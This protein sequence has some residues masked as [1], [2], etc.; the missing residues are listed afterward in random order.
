M[1]IHPLSGEEFDLGKLADIDP[2]H[3]KALSGIHF[4]ELI[5][6]KDGVVDAKKTALNFWRFGPE[7]DQS[8][9]PLLW[10]LLPADTRVP[11]HTI[12]AHLDL[13]SAFAAAFV[14]DSPLSPAPF[15]AQGT[16]EA[17][18]LSMSFGP[19]QDFI[20][21]SRST[22]DL[23]AGSCNLLARIAWEGL[24]VIADEIGPDAVIFPQLRGVPQVDLWL[25]DE[26]GLAA[27]RFANAEW[28]TETTDANPLFMAALPNKFVAI[29]PAG[30]AADLAEKVIAA[31]RSWVTSNAQAMLAELLELLE[32]SGFAND[33]ALPCH[34]NNW[35]SSSTASPKC[36]GPPCLSR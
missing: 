16:G 21:Q 10:Q 26:I 11:D 32:K 24:K 8:T 19:V 5:V 23:W 28:V 6:S 17:A 15:P 31:V 33:P 34:H 27:G 1:L 7:P 14:A 13:T 36:I 29:V 3:I 20:A 4:D 9:L 35:P 22:S 25:R 2:A 18:L 12:W 30:R